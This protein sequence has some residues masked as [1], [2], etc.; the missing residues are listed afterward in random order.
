MLDLVVLFLAKLK[1]F[2]V[3]LFVCTCCPRHCS[4]WTKVIDPL[5]KQRNVTMITQTVTV[6]GIS[7]IPSLLRQEG[8][9]L[10]LW[11]FVLMDDWIYILLNL[12]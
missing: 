4:V 10:F 7:R 1:K 12:H 2:S 6:L 3:C 8:I 11:C 9:V 5:V